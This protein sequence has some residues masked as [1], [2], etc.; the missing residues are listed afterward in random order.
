MLQVKPHL[1]MGLIF[2]KVVSFAELCF[3]YLLTLILK[4]KIAKSLEV[5]KLE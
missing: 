4:K 1:L 3:Y 2:K 5:P